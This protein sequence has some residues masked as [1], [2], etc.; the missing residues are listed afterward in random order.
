MGNRS[1]KT[2]RLI[3]KCASVQDPLGEGMRT[4]RM[5]AGAKPGSQRQEPLLALGWGDLWGRAEEEFSQV[6]EARGAER[7]F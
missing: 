3:L 4:A 1:I 6:Q 2:P 5:Q 7:L